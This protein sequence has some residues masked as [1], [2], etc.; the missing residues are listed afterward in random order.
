MTG[1]DNKIDDMDQCTFG[2]VEGVASAG[3]PLPVL[4]RESRLSV[5]RYSLPCGVVRILFVPYD[6]PACTKGALVHVS[7]FGCF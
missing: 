2:A 4:G 6:R 7:V 5:A 1:S 3:A